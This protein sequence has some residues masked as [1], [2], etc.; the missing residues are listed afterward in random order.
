LQLCPCEANEEGEDNKNTNAVT[1]LEI[2]GF[3]NTLKLLSTINPFIFKII[4]VAP[5]SIE[6]PLDRK[7]IN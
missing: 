6:N 3:I 1:A 7:R 2:Q 4:V 5:N